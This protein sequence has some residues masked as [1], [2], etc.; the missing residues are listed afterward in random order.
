MTQLNK[1]KEE[2]R[3]DFLSEL[4]RKVQKAQLSYLIFLTWAASV[5]TVFATT[6]VVYAQPTK[7]TKQEYSISATPPPQYQDVID[8]VIQEND[9][10][11]A[12]DLENYMLK[13]FRFEKDVEDSLNS[14]ER[15]VK[16]KRGDCDEFTLFIAY[17]LKRMGYYTEVLVIYYD[18]EDSNHN[19]YL[20]GHGIATFYDYE[21]QVW[22]YMDGY[23]NKVNNGK[24]S[25]PFKN[26][27]E[28]AL[29]IFE[30]IKKIEGVIGSE[31]T[32]IWHVMPEELEKAYRN[33]GKYME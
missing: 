6:S 8:Q 21:E 15:F 33:E 4:Y 26:H 31:P 2:Q 18:Y 23:I 13:N 19:R 20:S 29:D 7:D 32:K 14:P 1:V 24:I 28:M 3:K 11:T 10:K 30:G 16:K 27:E 5:F 9:L 25:K 12:K 22:R 17:T